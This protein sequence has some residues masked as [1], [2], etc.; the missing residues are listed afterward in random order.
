MSNS[1]IKI[2][3]FPPQENAWGQNGPAFQ[4]NLR[5]GELRGIIHINQDRCVGCDTCS[6]FCP[7]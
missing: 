2:Q 6:K 1:T 7:V 4:G 3:T 5:K